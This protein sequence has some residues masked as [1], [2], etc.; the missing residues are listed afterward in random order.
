MSDLFPMPALSAA[1]S[2]VFF[3]ASD[4]TAGHVSTNSTLVDAMKL[5]PYRRVSVSMV[6]AYTSVR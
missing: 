5:S 6:C 1:C 2:V 4:H 3:A